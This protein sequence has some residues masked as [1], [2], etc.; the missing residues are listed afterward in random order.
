MVTATSFPDIHTSMTP[1]HCWSQQNSL[2]GTSLP[3]SWG[4]I[5]ISY[6]PHWS[7][8]ILKLF[9]STIKLPF[10]ATTAELHYN[11]A[12]ILNFNGESVCNANVPFFNFGTNCCWSQSKTHNGDLNKTRWLRLN[13]HTGKFLHNIEAKCVWEKFQLNFQQIEK[14]AVFLLLL[15]TEILMNIS[16]RIFEA[17]M[18]RG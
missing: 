9:S 2:Q 17:N 7:R 1:L 4:R 6:D 12:N 13:S 15:T 3:P 14:I 16:C 8:D 11:L 5:L 18:A 10:C